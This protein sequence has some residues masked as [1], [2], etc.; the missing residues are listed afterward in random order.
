LPRGRVAL[1]A[2]LLCVAF[3]T[4]NIQPAAAATGCVP[5]GTWPAAR[6]DLAAQVVDLVN[7]HRA[8]LGLQA[9]A[10]SPTLTAAATWKARHMAA[11]SYLAHDDPA[12]PAART[13]GERLAECGYP[14]ASW[15]ENIAAGY[16]TAQAALDGWLASPGHRANLERPEYRATGVGA[17][18]SR[19]SWAQ[20]FGTAV[21]AGSALPA[22]APPAPIPAASPTLGAATS[23][24]GQAS[25]TH[26][27]VRVRCGLR[28]RNVSCRLGG[29]R[30]ALVRIALTRG[31][32]TYA[33]ARARVR[34]DPARVALHGVRRLRDGRYAL[35]VRA[36]LGSAVRERR[37]AF[38]VR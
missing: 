31:G 23:R 27:T 10:V 26:R 25:S 14:R 5:E 4:A 37:L 38:V 19:L 9:L 12:P 13:S 21:D 11:Y 2:A 8:R 18:G 35:V 7:A 1:R 24:S 15:G 32:R 36:A 30:G 22:A 20:A 17:A 33:R 6:G 28:S 34:S 16:E 29:V 3:V